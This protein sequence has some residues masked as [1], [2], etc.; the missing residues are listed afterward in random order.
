MPSSLARSKDYKSIQK[1]P[2]ERLLDNCL[3]LDCDIPPV[4]LMYSRFSHFLDI[5]DGIN[6]VPEIADANVV[7]LHM[8][9]DNFALAM[10]QF[11]D[12]K[13]KQRDE[14]LVHLNKIFN[15]QHVSLTEIPHILLGVIGNVTSDGHNLTKDNTTSIIVKFKNE[16]ARI[17]TLP[18][19]EV[20]RYVGHLIK[21][22]SKDVYQQWRVLYLGLTVV[23]KF[24]TLYFKAT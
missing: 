7:E 17:S 15:A 1:D 21:Q 2:K 9:V 19:V 20:V 3:D 18:Q 13:I 23:G 10:S 22:F 8:V 24:N 12:N 16:Q 4:H 11:F 14:G 6:N 5:V